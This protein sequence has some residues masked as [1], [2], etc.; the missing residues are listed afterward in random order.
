MIGGRS[1]ATKHN[2]AHPTSTKGSAVFG[3]ATG[4]GDQVRRASDPRGNHYEN[5]GPIEVRWRI[6]TRFRKMSL[7]ISAYSISTR[8]SS[9]DIYFRDKKKS[10]LAAVR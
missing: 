5:L 9:D 1:K 8:L 7:E 6:A 3:C 2:E 4:V 10:Q